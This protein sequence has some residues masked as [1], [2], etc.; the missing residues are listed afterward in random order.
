MSQFSQ[1]L[2]DYVQKNTDDKKEIEQALW[3]RYGVEQAVMILDMSGFSLMT[4]KYG[5]IHY[6]SM[7]QRM[8]AAT[9]PVI[10]RYRGHVVKF[11]ADN[12]FAHFESVSDAIHAAVTINH[13]LDGINMMTDKIFDIKVS[14]GIDYGKFLL[15]DD[16]DFFG[17]PVNRASKLGEDISS[18]GEI[19]VSKEAMATVL[20]EKIKT[21][22]VQYSISGITIEA[23]LIQY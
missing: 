20:D 5:I 2:L 4:Q 17:D 6:L 3:Q 12:C 1:L 19:L 8:Q 14:C 23:H 22:E 18:A 13:T 21:A 11:E 9:K 10:E 7:V 16:L 15:V